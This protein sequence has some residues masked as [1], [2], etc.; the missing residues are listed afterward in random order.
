[1]AVLPKVNSEK[2]QGESAPL[3]ALPTPALP[4]FC[5]SAVLLGAILPRYIG[6]A[7]WGRVTNVFDF[8]A[9]SMH[10]GVDWRT[11][12]CFPCDALSP[13]TVVMRVR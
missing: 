10:A 3:G 8:F 11:V 13:H 4:R 7:S 5:V 2:L 1:M 12:P 6:V 9:L